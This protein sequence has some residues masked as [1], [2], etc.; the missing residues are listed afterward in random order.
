A[1]E[2][3]ASAAIAHERYAVGGVSEFDLIDAQRQALQSALD[4]TRAQ[5][6][7]LTD[8]AALY[9]AL[10]GAALPESAAH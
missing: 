7:R 5:A 9:Q 8:T 3:Q 2:A 10:G 1:R 4:R 6:T